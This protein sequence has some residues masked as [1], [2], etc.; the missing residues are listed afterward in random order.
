MTIR[1][2]LWLTKTKG[3]NMKVKNIVFC[4]AMASIL[5][6]GVASAATDVTFA[7]KFSKATDTTETGKTGDA[8]TPISEPSKTAYNYEN[9]DGVSVALDSEGTDDIVQ[10]D[11]KGTSSATVE[12]D[13]NGISVKNTELVSGMTMDASNYQYILGEGDDAKTFELKLNEAGD[14]VVANNQFTETVNL[15]P[16]GHNE[17]ISVTKSSIVATNGDAED[18][19]P[20]MFV[21]TDSGQE[22]SLKNVGNETENIVLVRKGTNEQVSTDSGVLASLFDTAKGYYNTAK[23]AVTEAKN[24]TSDD[25]ADEI[26]IATNAFAKYTA[27]KNTLS[28]LDAKWQSLVAAR[29]SFANDYSN[30]E[31]SN[32]AIDVFNAPILETI[33]NEADS[34][35][36]L[37]LGEGGAI[38]TAID[39]GDAVTLSE[40]QKYA[41]A[42]D[43]KLRNDINA[44]DSKV[45]ELDENLSAGIASSVA[46]SSVAVA[47]VQRGEMSV[48]GGYGNY[49]SK[50]AVAFGAALGITDNWSANA[51]VGL[52]FGKDTKASFR[53]GTNYKFKL[54]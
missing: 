28:G 11:Y 52:G 8:N 32:A 36:E 2:L 29:Q 35:I 15:L 21:I 38:K 46:L 14:G 49:N 43:A 18:V 20:E 31:A 7:G 12:P 5:M 6:M 3:K 47:N 30:F 4:G 54:F 45:N 25:V 51:G 48:G 50:S 17:A 10:S 40:A 42:G 13:E 33:D 26:A 1:D 19:T 22:Y 44:L 37:A 39:A 24:N 9:P 16:D 23:G 41:D 53:V 34:R 27:D